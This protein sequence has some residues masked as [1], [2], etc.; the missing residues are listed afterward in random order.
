[1]LSPTRP[2]TRWH[3]IDGENPPKHKQFVKGNFI[4]VNSYMER[5]RTMMADIIREVME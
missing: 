3:V 4:P 2:S 5:D 1:M